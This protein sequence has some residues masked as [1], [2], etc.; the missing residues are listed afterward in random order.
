MLLA[1]MVVE[2]AIDVTKL[3]AGASAVSDIIAE[4]G[5]VAEESSVSFASLDTSFAGVSVAADS[6]VASVVGVDD[7][8][9]SVGASADAAV[10]GIGGIEAELS[11]IA[12]SAD[13]AVVGIGGVEAELTSMATA[14]DAVVVGMGGVTAAADTYVV[15]MGEVAASTDVAI[16][17]TNTYAT[18]L[19]S[20]STASD[21]VSGGLAL[22]GPALLGTGIAAAIVGA[23]T[24]KMAGDFEA[25]ITTL[26]TGAGESAKNLKMVSDGILNMAPAVGTTTDQLI[27]GM[28]QVESAG[29]RAGDGLN[30][31]KV[32][33]EGAK[34]Q[35]AD[36]GDVAKA[37]TIEM[38]DY[39]MKASDAA[40]AMNGLTAIVKN[41]QTAM[42]QLAPTMGSVLPIAAALHI[43]FPQV[44][45]AMATMTNA[46]VPA[47]Q[48]ATNLAHVLSAL[49]APSGV[50]VKAMQSVGLSAQQ[51]KDT[52]VN[53]GLPQALS[54]IEDHINAKFPQG[55]IAAQT[56]LKNVMGGLVGLKLDA[57]TGG[58]SL[59]TLQNNINNV[60]SAMNTGGNQVTGWA[61]KQADFNTK[62]DQAK[63]ALE[64]TGIEIGQKFLPL[65]SK[66]MDFLASPGFNSFVQTVGVGMVNAIQ[67]LVDKITV[68]VGW[69]AQ[70]SDYLQHNQFAMDLF[71]GALVAA[72]ILI[73]GPL[74]LAFLGWAAAALL[75]AI[76]TLIAMAPIILIGAL[77]A[78]VVAGIILA[79]QHWGQIM[80]WIQDLIG[81]ICNAVVNWFKWL[82]HTLVGGS[83]IPDM[84][85]GIVSW[86]EQLPGR[87]GAAIQDLWTKAVNLFNSFLTDALNFGSNIVKGIADGI[88]AGLHWIQGAI[89]N[90]T[91]FISDHLPHSPAK[92]GPL[93]DLQNQGMEISNQISKGM[94][95]GVPLINSAIGNMT[96]PITVG[97]SGVTTSSSPTPSNNQQIVIQNHFYVDGKEVTTQVMKRTVKEL[98]GHGL[99]K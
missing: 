84:I 44:G 30:I 73:G 6:V 45:G 53:Q 1:Q 40:T 36:L 33:A 67:G 83:I 42:A 74:V 62:M 46:G 49:S 29:Y 92:M 18:S 3:M 19:I 93:V 89:T 59:K 77:I 16:D 60:S 91:Q 2:Y 37:V 41:G 58:D 64:K 50:A 98:R 55:S 12:V 94:V 70:F 66:L 71:Y 26:Q 86:F 72:G 99:K 85:N 68:V 15:G 80:H 51:V 23:A 96:K 8:L 57:E 10:A 13:S 61:A 95:G 48:A 7:A 79:V 34:T 43:A 63:G 65:G 97:L 90:V 47:R 54:L 24:T 11:S 14:T 78:L 39:H 22:V 56:A 9:V 75:A 20:L 32:A 82:W 38:T 81:T 28:F 21:M 27:S 52:L 31:L 17:S 35:N 88:T 4:I 87:A 5:A 76:N 25:G 69:I